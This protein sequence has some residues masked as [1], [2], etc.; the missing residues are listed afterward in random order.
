[1]NSLVGAVCISNKDGMQGYTGNTTVSNKDGT[2]GTIGGGSVVNCGSPLRGIGL[3]MLFVFSGGGT[4]GLNIGRLSIGLN[5]G[6]LVEIVFSYN[7]ISLE[8]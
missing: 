2:A 4:I 3:Q 5:C 1:M 7:W 6:L 8:L